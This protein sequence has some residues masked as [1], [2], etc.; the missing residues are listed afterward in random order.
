MYDYLLGGKDHFQA[1]REAISGLLQAV[2]TART[3]AR[4][5]R[6]FLG[7]AVRY[8]VEEAGIRQF[9]DIGAGLPTANNVHEVA[10]AI[11][12]ETRVVYVD[13]DP[14]VLAH[15][16]AL[17]TSHPDGKTAYIQADLRGPEA[18][19]RDPVVRETLDFD[20]PVA[21]M[22]LAVLHF[23][24]DDDDPAG[25]LATLLKALAPGSYLVASQTT[26][27]F[28]EPGAA[29]DGVRAVHR[30]GLSFQTRT[31]EEF[32]RLAFT[33][34][35]M[36]DPGLVPV[37]EWRPKPGAILPLPAEVGYYGGVARK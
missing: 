28:H 19:L 10:Q 35:R 36:V 32:M 25:I 17:L 26:G 1:D 7:R 30:A 13:N 8:L 27:D 21:L 22:L 31:A 33:G 37:S 18:I 11:A 4:E 5:N 20:Q 12:P 29:A 24:P 9:L 6:A 2:P 16:R 34:L 23:F 14:I 15:A 3:G